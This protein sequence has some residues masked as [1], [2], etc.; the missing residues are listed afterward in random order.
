MK[1][2]SS[3]KINRFFNCKSI[4][5]I[6]NKNMIKFKVNFKLLKNPIKRYIFKINNYIRWMKNFKAQKINQ[7]K[8]T[9]YLKI[10]IH[11]IV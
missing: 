9:N 3:Y 7:I 8:I 1:M 10:I 2:K 4:T 5:S 11:L 6:Y